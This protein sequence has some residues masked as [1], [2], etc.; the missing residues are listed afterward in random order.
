MGTIVYSVIATLP[1]RQTLDD[2]VDWLQGGHLQG[3]LAGG[4][5]RAQI[6]RMIEPTLQVET[7]YE[8]SDRQSFD[9]YEREFAPTLRAEGRKRFGK[10]PGVSFARSIAERIADVSNSNDGGRQP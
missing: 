1:D 9:R 3:V 10:L 7:R 8:F 2:Y 5:M 4:A 6:H